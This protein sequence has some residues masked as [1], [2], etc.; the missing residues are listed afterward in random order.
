MNYKKIYAIEK[1]N[2]KRILKANS[3]VTEDSGIYILTRYDSGFKYAYIGQAKKLLT[4]LASHL[5]GYQHID[6]SIKKHGL[7]SVE[8]LTGWRIIT[9]KYDISELDDKEQEYILLYANKGY[10]LRNKT[11]GSQG[12]E[13]Q[14]IVDTQRKGYQQG[15][16]NGYENARKDLQKWF[17]YLKAEPLKDSKLNE[18]MLEKFNDFIENT[19]VINGNY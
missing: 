8:N 16:K 10:Q 12:K 9:I 1:A 17:K 18:R 3:G 6:L 5:K 14:N 15:L 7:Y 2:K 13:K 4:R 11:S 19:G